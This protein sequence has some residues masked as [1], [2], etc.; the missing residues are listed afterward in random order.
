MVIGAARN[1]SVTVL[2]NA[3]SERFRVQDY[4]S[5]VFA[6]LRLER[7]VK[8]NRL[9]CNHVHE[10]A[11]LHPW[12]HRRVD[13]LREFFFT[14][15]NPTAWAAQTFVRSGGHKLRVRDRARMLASRY[16]AGDMRHVYEQNRAY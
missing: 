1:D 4:L 3:G 16:K 11:A 8:T 9:R 13:R 7:F 15:H 2:R 10:G 12:K 5:L 14:Q 6:E